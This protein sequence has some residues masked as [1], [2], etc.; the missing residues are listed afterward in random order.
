MGRIDWDANDPLEV[1]ALVR[2]VAMIGP[3]RL[4][5]VRTKK[6]EVCVRERVKSKLDSAYMVDVTDKVWADIRERLAP[7]GAIE[8]FPATGYSWAEER[9]VTG[10]VLEGA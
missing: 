8:V 7:L 1:D 10:V 5:L 4:Y 3:T 6:N 2:Y 9:L